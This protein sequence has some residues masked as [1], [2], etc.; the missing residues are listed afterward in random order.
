MA[1]KNLSENDAA[2]LF[3]RRFYTHSIPSFIAGL[4]LITKTVKKKLF[5]IQHER[6]PIYANCTTQTTK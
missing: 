1:R 2:A 5:F 6:T 3:L 4:F